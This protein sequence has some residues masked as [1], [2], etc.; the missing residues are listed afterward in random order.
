MLVDR[1]KRKQGLVEK[2][3]AFEVDFFMIKDLIYNK[4]NFVSKF[5]LIRNK[6]RRFLVKDCVFLNSK[7]IYY[8]RKVKNFIESNNENENEYFIKLYED[9]IRNK[10]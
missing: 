8:L 3:L 5:I 10:N 9:R 6:S 1:K 7:L 2:K 4:L